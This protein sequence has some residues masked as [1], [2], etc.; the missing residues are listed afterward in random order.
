MT[1]RNLLTVVF[2][3]V[4]STAFSQTDSSI[5]ISSDADSVYF[6]VA[7]EKSAIANSDMAQYYLEEGV[8]AAIAGDYKGAEDKF[9]VGLLY[10]LTNKELLYNLGLAQYYQSKY[11]EAQRTFDAAADVDP[12]NPEIY[13]QRGLCKAMQ[14]DYTAAELD[15]KILLK[16]D[17]NHPMGNFNYGVLLLQMGNNTEACT[18][19]GIADANGYA[20]AP[21]IIAEYCSQ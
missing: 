9:R 15:F 13:N 1:P 3:S 8:T 20:D 14:D 18:Y 5:V 6:T 21:G 12:E 10:D 4:L 17:A 19:L 2:L 11:A 7:G 16:L